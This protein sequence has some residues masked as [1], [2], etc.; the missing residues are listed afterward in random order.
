MRIR[1]IILSSIALGVIALAIFGRPLWHPLQV[2]LLG[3]HTIAQRVAAIDATRKAEIEGLFA[4]WPP[5]HLAILAFKQERELELWEPGHRV[6]I[7]P[8]LAASGGPGPKLR[9]GDRQVPEGVYPVESLNPDS[10]FHLSLRVGYPNAVDRAQAARDGRERLGGD[11]MI[12]GGA[13]SIGCIA[14]GDP[15][16]EM[17]FKAVAACGTEGCTVIIAPER[18]RPAS[19][20]GPVWMAEVYDA[21]YAA[22]A[23]ARIGSSKR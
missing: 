1:T 9:E 22:A 13:S 11:I 14:V 16:V 2:R 17:L 7:F 8:I 20:V 12:H 19:V 21:I 10:A 4:T 3:R 5:R 23:G 6:A 15:A 18:K